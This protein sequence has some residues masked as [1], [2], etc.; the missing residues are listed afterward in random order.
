MRI[1]NPSAK[2][3]VSWWKELTQI[4]K[5]L[6]EFLRLPLPCTTI[7]YKVAN[8]SMSEVFLQQHHWSLQHKL[9]KMGKTHFSL[10][11][12]WLLPILFCLSTQHIWLL[13][14]Y[15]QHHGLIL[16]PESLVNIFSNWRYF[17]MFIQ[18]SAYPTLRC[19]WCRLAV[20]C[21]APLY[22]L[23]LPQVSCP[24]PQYRALAM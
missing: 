8:T 17:P 3:P 7:Q 13:I 15:P 20:L 12:K 24:F 10:K 18:V 19:P 5:G 4:I 2:A 14:Y 23:S 1:L 21:R 22:P 6:T 11:W 16:F 9:E